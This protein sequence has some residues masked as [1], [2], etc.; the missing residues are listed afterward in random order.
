MMKRTLIGVL[1]VLAMA[2]WAGG[3]PYFAIENPQA[4]YSPS[5][6]VTIDLIYDSGQVIGIMFDAI[7]DNPGAAAIGTTVSYT[8]PTAWEKLWGNTKMNTNGQLLT[9]SAA[10]MVSGA[11]FPGSLLYSF[12]YHVPQVAASTYLTI[13]SYNND[14][15]PYTPAEVDNLDGSYWNPPPE[16][17]VT[18]HVIPEPAT[19][20]LLGLGGLLLR[21][22]K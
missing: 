21:R 10:N 13:Q 9:Y 20:L 15:N 19:L 5:D 2:S 14:G 4:N 16:L 6:N 12:V 3:Q 22:R 7:T 8:Y 17:S 18:I 1:L 11:V